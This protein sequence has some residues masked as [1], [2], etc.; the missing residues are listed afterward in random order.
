M[1]NLQQLRYRSLSVKEACGI[2]IFKG[3]KNGVLTREFFNFTY[4][5]P[6]AKA[7]YQ[8]IKEIR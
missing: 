3:Y 2:E 1:C 7:F 4:E 5:H 6:M 8:Y